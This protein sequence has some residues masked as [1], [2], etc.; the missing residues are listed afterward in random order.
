M[1]EKA[2]AE[3]GALWEKGRECR[4]RRVQIMGRGLETTTG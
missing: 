2:E 3:K 4:S 1:Q